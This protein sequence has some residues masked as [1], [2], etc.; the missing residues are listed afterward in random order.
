M[1]AL[2]DPMVDFMEALCFLLA[3]MATLVIKSFPEDLH[4]RLKS[5]AA[6]H[7]R[8]VTQETIF[9]LEKVLSGETGGGVKSYWANRETLPGFQKALDEGAFTRGTDSTAAISEERDER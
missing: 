1:I 5:N 2:G 6:E 9:L 8:S 7:R 3:T 4:A